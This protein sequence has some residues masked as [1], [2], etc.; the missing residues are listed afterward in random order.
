MNAP[1]NIR[2]EQP[3]DRATVHRI[4]REAFGQDA[5]ADLVDRLRA[6]GKATLSL[7]AEQDD[8]I[9]G[10]ILFSPVTIESAAGTIT[11]LGLAPM[12]VLPPHQKQGIGTVLVE[13][14]LALLKAAGHRGVV[15]LGHPGYYPRFG[16]IPASTFGIRCGYDAPDEAFMALELTPDALKG[17]SGLAK[18]Q[19]EFAGV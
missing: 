1:V 5:E 11:L 7:V 9:V 17:C 6:N 15:V 3:G 14:A 8:R 2:E 19:P 4:N 18:F 10:H 13:R 12:A 16:F